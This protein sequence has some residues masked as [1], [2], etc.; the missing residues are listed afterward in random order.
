M[1]TGALA[2][3]ARILAS[4]SWPAAWLALRSRITCW[5]TLREVAQLAAE[6]GPAGLDIGVFGDQQQRA[7]LETRQR[8]QQ[9]EGDQQGQ[10]ATAG[11]DAEGEPAGALLA[12][13][14]PAEQD[15]GATRAQHQPVGIRNA[16][17]ADFVVAGSHRI[18]RGL[19]RA[20]ALAP[21]LQRGGDRRVGGAVAKHPVAHRMR[22]DLALGVD[23]DSRHRAAA[24]GRFLGQVGEQ[25]AARQAQRPAEHRG[26]AAVGREHRHRQDHDRLARDARRRDAGDHR[27]VLAH[28]VLEVVAVGDVASRV[29]H[30]VLVADEDHLAVERNHEDAREERRQD[31]LALDELSELRRVAEGGRRQM[32]G[33]AA[34]GALQA[35]QPL[36]HR[37]SDPARVVF[38]GIQDDLLAAAPH[39]AQDEDHRQR[40]A[41]EDQHRTGQREANLQRAKTERFPG[42]AHSSFSVRPRVFLI[43]AMPDV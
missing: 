9:V 25:R 39:L 5:R 27:P 6:I 4:S 12:F 21:L 42:R 1:P 35:D 40:H 16:G 41:G 36:R 34:Q 24:V 2:I 20:A 3:T 18:A 26:D 8:A 14:D 13:D 30:A 22:E 19:D 7:L 32:R 11:G 33:D 28:R 17:E 29:A 31:A 23:D 38:L 37:P 15:V 43:L 10:Q